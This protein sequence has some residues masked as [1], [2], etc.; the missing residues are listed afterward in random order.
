MRERVDLKSPVQQK[1]PAGICE[2]GIG[3]PVSLPRQRPGDW[4]KPTNSQT[5]LA[6]SGSIG[7]PSEERTARVR[8]HEPS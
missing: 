3:K 1:L 4:R 5:G 8:K 6:A 2:G 7:C